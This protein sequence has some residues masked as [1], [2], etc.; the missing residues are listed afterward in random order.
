MRV[1]ST[2]SSY[3]FNLFNRQNVAR[4]TADL[5]KASQE[6]A[7]GK[8]AD[9]FGELGPRAAS[10][11]KLRAREANTQTFLTSN[12]VLGNKLSAMMASVEAVRTQIQGVLENSLANATRPNSGAEMLQ[13]QARSAL[14]GLVASMNTSFNGDFLFSGLKSDTPPYLRWNQTN[15]TSGLSPEDVL[16]NIVGAG[17]ADATDAAT[18]IA[19]IDLSFASQN[20]GQ[21]T[22]NFEATFYQGTAALDGGGQPTRQVAAWVNVGQQVVYG[23]RGNDAPFIEAYKGLAMLASTDVSQLD[24]AAYEAWMTKVID[25]LSQGQEGLLDVS[26]RIGFNQQIVE[27]T[28]RQLED[29]SMVQ[30][31]QIADFE[32]VDPYEA[33]TRLNLLETQLEASYQVSARL[34]NLTILQFLR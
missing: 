15:G 9:V 19:E 21:P 22:H 5:Q 17:P 27:K 4:T 20:G 18:M 25:S 2:I 1:L 34:G 31:T 6:A 3:Q 32:N 28:Q 30:R 11:I 16:Q 24:P 26:A 7:S 23:A 14:E 8:R 12:G 33:V 10:V 13:L 29:I